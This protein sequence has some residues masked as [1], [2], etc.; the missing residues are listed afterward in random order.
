M[1]RYA[2]LALLLVSLS[3]S[4]AVWDGSAVAGGLGD[5]PS[6]GLYGAC[7]S[8]PH[9]TS[10]TITNLENGKTV[11][12]SITQGIDNPG[13]FIALSPKAAAELG[14]HSG[15]SARIRAVALTA[16]Q[17]ETSLPPA[18]T[19]ESTDPDFNPKVYVERE[20]AAV[21]AAA[22]PSGTAP[23]L[24]AAT[25]A[26]ETKAPETKAP[27]LAATTKAPETTAP[28]T[29]P[30]ATGAAEAATAAAPET[31]GAETTTAATEPA[32]APEAKPAA[33]A[34]VV[35]QPDTLNNPLGAST[36]PG[37]PKSGPLAA[38]LPTPDGLGSLPAQKE[39]ALRG[40]GLALAP[41]I[42]GGTQRA[43]PRVAGTRTNLSDPN[44]PAKEGPAPSLA[45]EPATPETPAAPEVLG[46]ALPPAPGL[47]ATSARLADPN[48][49]KDEKGSIASLGRPSAPAASTEAAV[50]EPALAPE[51]L[52]E[53]I[54]S[55]VTSPS[56]NPPQPL[57]AEAQPP[58]SVPSTG[59]GPEA[60]ALERP[61]YSAQ[62]LNPELAEASEPEGA[63]GGEKPL[64]LADNL[65]GPSG[66][67]LPELGEPAIPSPSESLSVE[68]PSKAESG[69]GLALGEP[70]IPGPSESLAGE[71]PAKAESG[72]GLALGEPT[73]PSPKES[74][75][76]EHPNSIEPS[77]ALAELAEPAQ[78]KPAE[79][80]L[81]A[82]PEESKPVEEGPAI[83]YG[84]EQPAKAASTSSEL[85]NPLPPSPNAALGGERPSPLTGGEPLVVLEPAAPRPPQPMEKPALA[86][87]TSNPKTALA[88]PKPGLKAEAKP[89]VKAETKPETKPEAPVA[90][91]SIKGSSPIG[92]AVPPA[93]VPLLKG[94]TK[95]SFYVQIGVYGSNDSLQSAIGGF[96]ATYPLAVESLTTK[97]GS[98]AFRLFVGPL[99]RDEGGVVLLR[100]RALGFKDAYLRKGT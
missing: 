94:L 62:V 5:F 40:G 72:L 75:S 37:P 98:P 64:A 100:I 99:S 48:L 67:A 87:T 35:E 80:A 1:K 21:K 91:A 34:A 85:A 54:L 12:V 92:A 53:A 23:E 61:S 42:L 36:P 88:E 24:A 45:Q 43:T 74:L 78:G 65:K 83:A 39:P 25:A 17:A 51:E 97:A 19:G 73:A 70:S 69:L 82:K 58:A 18:R 77:Q 2:A 79:P 86:A 33:G 16:S 8:F 93:S 27:E 95:G 6:D 52:P 50:S 55:R 44:V 14:M 90:V 66:S 47:S 68:S 4:A 71:R 60:L 89:V 26:P 31:G 38:K 49:P 41:E 57:L 32:T 20:K 46:G 30:P 22:S 3:L 28:E 7:N 81:A 96:K 11:T 56:S 59:E 29:A 9:D 13:V 15:S 10:V 76:A 84:G 63:A